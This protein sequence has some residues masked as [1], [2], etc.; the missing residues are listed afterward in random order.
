MFNEILQISK[1][2]ICN[3]RQ[4]KEAIPSEQADAI[5]QEIA[6]KIIYGLKNQATARAS[7]GGLLSMLSTANSTIRK[8]IEGSLTFS[9]ED[10]FNLLPAATGAITTVLP[11]VFQKIVHKAFDPNDSTL[12]Q[13]ILY[14]FL[15]PDRFSD[16]LSF[17]KTA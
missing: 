6:L 12:S 5:Y 2:Q 14:D 15:Q 16:F 7:N 3:D 1:E 8:S 4:A 13:E 9:L 10:K 17:K 11:L